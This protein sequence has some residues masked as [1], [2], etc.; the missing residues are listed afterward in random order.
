[1]PLDLDNL[2]YEN[3]VPTLILTWVVYRLGEAT[4]RRHLFLAHW[5][6]RIGFTAFLGWCAW[7]LVTRPSGRAGNLLV[8]I[9]QAV[10]LGLLACGSTWLVTPALHLVRQLVIDRPRTFFASTLRARGDRIEAKR[11]QRQRQLA[12]QEEAQ[13]ERLLAPLREQQRLEADQ[14]A[15]QQTAERLVREELRT[16]VEL[17]YNLHRP[18]LS[19]RFTPEMFEQFVQKYLGDD[20]PVDVVRL[21]AA[22]L[23]QLLAQHLEK[24]VP[25]KRSQSL[26]ELTVWLQEQNQR[27]DGVPDESL[28]ELLRAMLLEQ[29]TNRTAATF[30]EPV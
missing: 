26:E 13:R 16:R 10:V 18:E 12:M 2:T 9:G 28:K 1:M 25:P 7:S 21:R 11:Q 15:K 4:A 6:P 3:V 14:R 27:I 17:Y 20:R 29:Y 24:I 19:R 23:E 30:Q 5:G 22:Q 8:M